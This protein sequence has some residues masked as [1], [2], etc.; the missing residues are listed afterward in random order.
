MDPITQQQALAAAGAGGDKVYV[1]DV[2][3]TFLYDGDGATSHTI[4]NNIDIDGEGGLVWVK[5]RTTSGASH[6]L[7]DTERG[8]NK[9]LLSNLNFAEISGTTYVKSFSSTGF[10]VGD[11]VSTNYSGD[12]Y[13]SWTFRKAPGFFDVVIW[14][15]NGVNGRQISHSLGSVPGTIFVKRTSETSNWEVWH[16]SIANDE[17]LQ[18]NS[19]NSVATGGPWNNTAPTSTHFTVSSDS[20]VN[21]S[22]ETY[23]AY[24]F[25]HDEQS[26][27]T[28]EDESVIKC[29]SYTGN[30]TTSNEVNVGFEPQWLLIKLTSTY[31]HSWYVFDSMRGIVTGG[32]DAS[33]LANSN[34]SEDTSFSPVEV[35]STGF[36]LTHG[37]TNAVNGSGQNYIYIAIRRPHKPPSAGTEVFDVQQFS[38]DLNGALSSSTVTADVVISAAPDSSTYANILATRLTEQ[39][40][41]TLA[42]SAANTATSKFAYDK[43]TGVLRTDW[44][45]AQDCIDYTFKRAPRFFDVVCYEGTSNTSNNVSHNLGVVPSMMILKKRDGSSEWAVRTVGSGDVDRTGF[46]LN[47]NYAI[48]NTGFATAGLTATTFNPYYISTA[49]SNGNGTFG[50]NALNSSGDSYVA[51]LFGNLAGVSKVGA[52]SGTGN[53]INVDCGFTAG[54]RFVMIKRTN[55]TGDW[56]VWDTVRGITVNSDPYF[57]LNS[58]AAEVTNTDYIDPLGAGFTV[59]SSA[60]AALNASGG[61]YIFL[62]IA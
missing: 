45:G 11:A 18:L 4:T 61:T 48:T 33:L 46:Q 16:R 27:G 60:P 38:S 52:Y 8:A 12:E 36:K 14:T 19:T 41:N 15:G 32:N 34:N 24:L 17:Y 59:T 7:V 9:V 43:Q 35:T 29:G 6:I 53:N 42:T 62:A 1:D 55:S 13:C 5:S 10:V 28:D 39:Y 22:S 3:S 50:D 40:L 26:F 49:D 20:D 56:Y 30:G 37:S 21:A 47:R 31:G 54:A 2:F 23:V 25:A 57:L 51:Y 44:F 58:A